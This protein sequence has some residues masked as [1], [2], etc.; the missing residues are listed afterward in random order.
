MTSL[1][2]SLPRWCPLPRVAAASYPLADKLPEITFSNKV[3]ESQFQL[4]RFA[5]LLRIFWNRPFRFTLLGSTEA[6]LW[7]SIDVDGLISADWVAMT[8]WGDESRLGPGPRT[9]GGLMSSAEKLDGASARIVLFSTP[10][11]VDMFGAD[12]VEASVSRTPI[13]AS[14]W[15]KSPDPVPECRLYGAEGPEEDVLCRCPTLSSIL[16]SSLWTLDVSGT[17]ILGDGERGVRS[18]DIWGC[19]PLLRVVVGEDREP[20]CHAGG[21][22]PIQIVKHCSAP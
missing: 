13:G 3:T 6:A 11:P 18:W 20:F 17:G 15:C 12:E 22:G 4:L 21:W 8:G 1:W 9:V 10:V 5:T 2:T 19:D 7:F 16:N 14:A